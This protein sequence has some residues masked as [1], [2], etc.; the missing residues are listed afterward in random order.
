MGH[1]EARSARRTAPVP[2]D[3]GSGPGGRTWIVVWD[4]PPQRAARPLIDLPAPVIGDSRCGSRKSHLAE[5]APSIH[6]G[7]GAVPQL[8]TVEAA[9]RD[10]SLD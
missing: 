2:R 6:D 9:V 7:E 5:G 8:L 10:L 4:A 3:H 1:A